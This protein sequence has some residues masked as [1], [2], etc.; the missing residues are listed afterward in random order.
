MR[1]EACI[2]LGYFGICDGSEIYRHLS[3]TIHG[4]PLCKIKM[5]R[6]LP[7]TENVYSF[8]NCPKCFEL[9]ECCAIQ[10]K[11]FQDCF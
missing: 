11:L 6:C 4:K 1:G 9:A 2:P 7:C 3:R 10:L 5:R 8:D